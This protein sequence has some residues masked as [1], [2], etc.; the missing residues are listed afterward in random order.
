MFWTEKYGLTEEE[1][2]SAVREMKIAEVKKLGSKPGNI[3][4]DSP[5]LGRFEYIYRGHGKG[6]SMIIRRGTYLNAPQP[7][8]RRNPLRDMLLYN[9]ALAKWRKLY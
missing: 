6:S 7:P 9:A 8:T 4:F 3:V 1:Y 2:I 5:V